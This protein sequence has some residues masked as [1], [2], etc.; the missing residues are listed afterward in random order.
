MH[1]LV[2]GNLT[3]SLRDVSVAQTLETVR[4]MYGYDYRRLASG[5]FVMPASV[6]SRIFQINYLDIARLGASRTLV[7][8]GSITDVGQ[9][10]NNN[11]TTGGSSQ[12]AGTTGQNQGGNRESEVT[13]TSII[14]RTDSDFW[15]QLEASLKAIIGTTAERSVVINR[16]SGTIAVR[17][18]P[19]E[20][21]N[22]DE[23]LR[24]IQTIVTRQ[25]VLEAKIIEVELS[26][27]YQAGINWGA[28][29][30]NGNQTLFGG[31]TAPA[32]G[33]DSPDAEFETLGAF[34]Q[35]TKPVDS[36]ALYVA[37]HHTG[38][39]GAN[40][41]ALANV[42][43]APGTRVQI[44]AGGSPGQDQLRLTPAM[45]FTSVGASRRVYILSGPV[46]YLC[47]PVNGTLARYSGYAIASNQ[48]LRDT[49][50]ELL[51]AGAARSVIAIGIANCRI[52]ATANATASQTT[53]HLTMTFRSGTD[54]L[55]F[56]ISR[57]GGNAG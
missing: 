14:S 21:R 48:A 5:Y 16:Q 44:D 56:D 11:G 38:A 15:M 49:D 29:F 2:K 28:V 54:Q 53:Q 35:L 1:P 18:M 27:A 23:Y 40:A 24:Q 55:V 13:G 36:T 50:A 25:V 7:S 52:A 45:T 39:A 4:E 8:S 26:D 17:A 51:G 57:V 42:I 34:A 43:S 33:F 41:W 12:Q 30:R 47:N 19:D 22:V 9:G 20:L 46:S 6:Q 32:D 31:Q 3:L 37:L 10:A